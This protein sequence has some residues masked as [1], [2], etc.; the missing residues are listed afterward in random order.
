MNRHWAM[1]LLL[2]AML[3]A[4]LTRDLLINL[5]SSAIAFVLGFFART[6]YRNVKRTAQERKASKSDMRRLPSYTRS[7][8]ISYYLKRDR[9][10]DLFLIETGGQKRFIPFLVKPAWLAEQPEKQ[11]I[12]QEIPQLRSD[13]AINRKVLNRRKSYLVRNQDGAPWND[14][15]ACAANV[16][17]TDSGPQIKVVLA[18]YFQYMSVCGALEDETYLASR[19]RT[20][21]R[22]TPIRDRALASAEDAMQCKLNAHAMG[23]TVAL[24]YKDGN[25]LRVLIQERSRSV[26]TYGGAL[27]VVPMFGC[28]TTDLS[29]R[30]EVSLV[31]NFLR[32]VYEE[33][34]GGTS[35]EYD[36]QHV[37]PQWF[38]EHP[39]IAYMA[40]ALDRG[41]LKLN[42]L[43][44]GF[45]ALN[46]QL[47]IAGM[48]LF[49]DP[50]F[51][52]RELPMMTGN[53]EVRRIQ[54]WDLFGPRLTAA[55]LDGEF[56]PACAF[57]LARTREHFEQ[58]L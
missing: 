38:F 51:I 1:A 36:D 25:E 56:T 7:W 54:A 3:G 52:K 29:E 23:M 11:L 12:L 41:E 22:S 26:S 21:G 28:Q 19:S 18:E 8:I 45:D 47:I 50:G 6:G 58:D 16:K 30:T 20:R 46:G 13:V 31:H 57:T 34:Y 10:Q 39:S 9:L 14:L 42:L 32:E 2:P 48:V 24:V 4:H 35:V 55:L 15:H 43:G 53:W 37:D 49:D 5:L 44:F 33:L 40:N 27:G 17:D